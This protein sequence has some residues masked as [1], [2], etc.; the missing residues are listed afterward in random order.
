MQVPGNGYMVYGRPCPV[1]WIC[2]AMSPLT[3]VSIAS[4]FV[5]IAFA[6]LLPN[7]NFPFYDTKP[8]LRSFARMDQC[9]NS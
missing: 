1:S 8:S 2:D 4:A 7:H 6:V 3:A 5:N 9:T